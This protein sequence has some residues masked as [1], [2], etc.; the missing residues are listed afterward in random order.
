MKELKHENIV[1]L[2][3]VIHT[4][5]LML[6][7]EFMDRDLKK[8][9]DTRG[10]R[11]QLDYVTI[12]SFMQQLLRG[13]AFCHDN[14]VLHRDLKP[15]NL[16]INTKGQL[17]LADFG[18][19]RAFGI[20]VNTFSNEVVTLW[21]RAPDVLLGSRTYNTSIDIWS[22]GCIMAEMYTGRPLFPGTRNEDQL[23]KIFRLMGTPSER[24]WPGISQLPEYKP[25][26]QSYATQS[27]QMIVPQI[28]P[29]GL[30]LLKRMLQ[31]CP[32]HRLTAPEALRHPWFQDLPQ[33]QMRAQQQAQQQQ[34]HGQITSGYG[35]PGMVSQGY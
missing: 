3:D 15:Q 19:A 30:D 27:L 12:K 13:I 33:L 2:H 26:F 23:Q 9:M 34:Q 28:D 18:L 31:L 8:Y 22:A 21:Y 17:K 1:S 10:D 5:K 16:L 20:P 32:E 25:N 29:L 11:G 7:F 35:N 6:V 24:T 4:D 14:R